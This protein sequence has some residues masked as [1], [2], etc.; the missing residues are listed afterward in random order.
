MVKTMNTS[1]YVH[2]ISKHGEQLSGPIGQDGLEPVDV[3]YDD[4]AT[5]EQA[6]L[7]HKEN[8]PDK[9][10]GVFQL[11]SRAEMM[12]NDSFKMVDTL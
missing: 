1:F 12:G 11:I 3:P 8:N 2:V 7:H 10:Y 6:A 9:S 4:L 5:A